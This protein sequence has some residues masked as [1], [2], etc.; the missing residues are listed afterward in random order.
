MAKIRTAD[1]FVIVDTSI[2]VEFF[3]GRD[4]EIFQSGLDRIQ[5]SPFVRLELLQ[6]VRKQEL[7]KVGELLV[8]FPVIELK[9]SLY[10]EAEALLPEARKRGLSFG[11]IDYLI[12]LQA[13]QMGGMLLSLDKTMLRLA[14][15][16]GVQSS[17]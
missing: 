7:K 2:F 15:N 6:G 12:V 5:L 10:S 4:H 11:L 9:P 13:R 17:S 1:R 14:N 16:L 8:G 3:H